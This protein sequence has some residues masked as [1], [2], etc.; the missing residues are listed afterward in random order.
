MIYIYKY[1]IAY[2]EYMHCNIY[3]YILYQYVG[4]VCK[5]AF[6]NIIYKIH[7]KEYILYID[8]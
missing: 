2:N 3:I 8:I 6:G 1:K 5:H 4:T 7:T